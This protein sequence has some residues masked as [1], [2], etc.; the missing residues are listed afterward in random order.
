MGVLITVEKK[1]SWNRQSKPISPSDS[2]SFRY[3][4]GVKSSSRLRTGLRR[5]FFTSRLV[6]NKVDSPL[7]Q[8]AVYLEKTQEDYGPRGVYNPAR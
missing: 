6:T 4:S 5:L 8:F 1:Q 3:L 7:S 2:R